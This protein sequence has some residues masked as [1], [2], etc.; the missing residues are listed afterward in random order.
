[1]TARKLAKRNYFF[2]ETLDR[3]GI[4]TRR[5]TPTRAKSTRATKNVGK[6]IASNAKTVYPA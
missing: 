3:I 5:A 6:K 1:L 4:E 2:G